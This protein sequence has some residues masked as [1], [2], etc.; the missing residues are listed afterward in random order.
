MAGLPLQQKS[1]NLTNDGTLVRMQQRRAEQGRA[2]RVGVTAL[3]VNAAATV[4]AVR[5]D[6]NPSGDPAVEA[7]GVAVRRRRC[8]LA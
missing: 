5:R 8:R 3:R 4:D 6:L 7:D 1:S 2:A